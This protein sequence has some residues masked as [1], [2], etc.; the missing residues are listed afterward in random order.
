MGREESRE[1]FFRAALELCAEKGYYEVRMDDVVRRAGASKGGLYHHFTSKR[2][3]FLQAFET[4]VGEIQRRLLAL[5][6]PTAPAEEL[7]RRAFGVLA[8][9]ASDTPLIRS[10][11]EFYVVGMHDEVVRKHFREFYGETLAFGRWVLQMGIRNGE[12]RP[13]IDPDGVARALFMG[14]DGMMLL[15]LALAEQE[16]TRDVLLGYLDVMLRGIAAP[17]SAERPANEEAVT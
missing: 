9:M 4:A 3:L 13:D 12:F 10:L 16:R 7:L 2:D 15:H 8:D 1:K 11:I 6:D 17:V 14:G 5:V